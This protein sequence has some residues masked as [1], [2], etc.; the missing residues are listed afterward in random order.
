MAMAGGVSVRVP[1][2]QGYLYKDGY[3]FSKS[4]CV[5][6]FDAG[7]DGVVFGSGSGLC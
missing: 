1:H 4:G 5:R 3:I 2:A 6:P 7:A